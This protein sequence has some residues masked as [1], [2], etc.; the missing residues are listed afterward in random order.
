MISHTVIQDCLWLNWALPEQSLP[1][2]PPPLV[3]DVCRT[4]EG[5]FVF[6]SAMLFRQHGL[7]ARANLPGVSHPQCQFHACALDGEGM[8]CAWVFR[9]LLPNWLATSVRWVAGRPARGARLDYPALGVPGCEGDRWSWSVR[10]TD[11]LAV[12]ASLASPLPGSGP[13]LGSFQ[14]TLAYFRRQRAEY[15]Q[16]RG[17]WQ[18]V[19]VDRQS[20]DAMP[21]A[22][23]VLEDALLADHLPGGQTDLPLLHSCWLLPTIKTSFEYASEGEHAAMPDAPAPL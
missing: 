13:S 23:V 19:Q 2:P 9:M 18:R 10:R 1:P 14:K 12:E 3:Y 8:E 6:V 17:R 22:A 7:G 16:V 15:V 20:A 11:E 4:D 21:V 5:G